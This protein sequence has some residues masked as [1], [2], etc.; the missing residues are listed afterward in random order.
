LGKRDRRHRIAT[1]RKSKTT[2]TTTKNDD[3]ELMMIMT[4]KTLALLTWRTPA[5]DDLQKRRLVILGQVR[6]RA[7]QP[8]S[9]RG[10]F[11]LEDAENV[12]H[13]R[14]GKIA[15]VDRDVFAAVADWDLDQSNVC[16]TLISLL[17]LLSRHDDRESF[18]NRS[19]L[20]SVLS[21]QQTTKAQTK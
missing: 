1:R 4:L 19:L 11:R 6:F 7:L 17:L 14:S 20:E 3:D 18:L 2:K 21:A 8:H 12:L 10:Q 16:I 9:Q 15:R 13:V 5:P